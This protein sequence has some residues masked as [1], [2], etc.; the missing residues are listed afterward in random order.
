[1]TDDI[2]DWYEEY[3]E[4]ID[5]DLKYGQRH[6][7]MLEWFDEAREGDD[8]PAYSLD[9]LK[10]ARRIAQSLKEE[11]F[12]L[13]CDVWMAQDYSD[14]GEVKKERDLLTDAAL[15]ARDPKY[16]GTP[17]QM[18]A[19]VMLVNNLATSDPL[20]YAEEID[21]AAEYVRSTCG[22]VSEHSLRILGGVASLAIAQRDWVRA[23]AVIRAVQETAATIMPDDL[24]AVG[25][26]RAKMACVQQDWPKMLESADQGLREGK[27][28]KEVKGSFALARACAL[29]ALNDLNAAKNEYQK[30]WRIREEMADGD[31]YLFSLWYWL[32]QGDRK[33]AIELLLEQQKDIE[34]KGRY[35]EQ[36]VSAKWLV[37][38]YT[39]EGQQGEAEKWEKKLAVLSQNLRKP[40]VLGEMSC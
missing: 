25:Y 17:Q 3:C 7:E 18:M 36:A 8:D 2:W 5:D 30:G 34:G 14:L 10:K 20:G 26:Y 29:A 32:N 21:E 24:W 12:V 6:M 15:R 22:S 38:L 39:Q 31:D 13:W 1:M 11:V 40:E 16:D 37:E 27:H 23:E 9:C 19:N 33:S 4:T 35:W 28:D